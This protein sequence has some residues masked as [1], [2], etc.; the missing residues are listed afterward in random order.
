MAA[1]IVCVTN[2]ESDSLFFCTVVGPDE[3]SN[4]KNIVIFFLQITSFLDGAN[5]KLYNKRKICVT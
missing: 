2:Y 1:I 4:N 3:S 5:A